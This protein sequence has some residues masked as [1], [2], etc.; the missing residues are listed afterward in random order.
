MPNRDNEIVD[1]LKLGNEKMQNNIRD[2][3]KITEIVACNLLNEIILSLIL[4]SAGVHI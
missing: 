1:K 4:I 2:V 3:N